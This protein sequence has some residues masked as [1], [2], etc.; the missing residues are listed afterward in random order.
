MIEGEALV[1]NDRE[2]VSLKTDVVL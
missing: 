1:T 2:R